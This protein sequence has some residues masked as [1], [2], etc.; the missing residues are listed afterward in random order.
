MTSF[1]SI[2]DIYLLF[3]FK[4]SPLSSPEKRRLSTKLE[5]KQEIALL[6][7]KP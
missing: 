1:E 4:D 3:F 7:E 5:K 2:S 6:F